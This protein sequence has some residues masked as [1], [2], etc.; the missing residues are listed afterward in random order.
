MFQ[1]KRIKVSKKKEYISIKVKPDKNEQFNRHDIQTFQQNLLRGIMQPQVSEK[2]TIVYIA[3]NGVMLKKYLKSGLSK[4]DFFQVFIQ[5]LEVLQTVQR[6]EMNVNNLVLDLE[7]TF[8]NES[9]KEVQMIYK[10]ISNPEMSAQIFS[11]L[12]SVIHSTVFLISEDMQMVNELLGYMK[13]MQHFSAQNIE[14]Y[15]E[16]IYP[17]IFMFVERIKPE[18]ESVPSSYLN[19]PSKQIYLVRL[20]THQRIDIRKEAFWIGKEQSKVDY[21]IPDNLSVSRQ[22]AVIRKR[23][24]SFFIQDNHSTNKTFVNNRILQPQQEAEIFNGDII[25]LAN[26]RLVF[27]IE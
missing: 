6:Y 2:N 20:K 8:I 16:Q 18:K 17:E 5:L 15:I 1:T 14:D 11:F 7:Y 25:M 27:H 21:C 13:R 26:E 9:T 19:S 22:H 4:K 23:N 3:P 10:P 12:Y 24:N